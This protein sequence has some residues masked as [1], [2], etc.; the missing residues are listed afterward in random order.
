MPLKLS[1]NQRTLF[2]SAVTVL[3]VGSV[4]FLTFF[5][6]PQE[7]DVVLITIDAL[8]ADH[9]GCYGYN[10]DTS[11]NIDALAREGTLFTQAIAQAS[12]TP[13]S[14]GI[15]TT[16]TYPPTHRLLDWGDTLNPDIPTLAESLKARGYK[17]VFAGANPAFRDGLHGSS[18]GFDE[19][20]NEGVPASVLT[21]KASELVG[22]DRSKPFFLWI[23]YMDVHDYAPSKEFEG[24]Y[25]NDKFYDKQKKLPIIKS[26]AGRYSF[27]GIA[28]FRAKKHG[29]IDNPDYYVALYDSAIRSVDQQIGFLLGNLAPATGNRKTLVIITADHGEMLGEHGCYFHH[30]TFLY[31]P[32]LKVPFILHCP[33][34]VPIKKVDA[35]IRAGLDVLPTVLSALKIKRP[36][37]IQGVALIP[38]LTKSGAGSSYVLSETY[39]RTSVRTDDWKLIR[40]S[41]EEGFSGNYELFHLKSDPGEMNNL[42]FVE[43]TH[44]ASLKEK[45]D[46]HDEKFPNTRTPSPALSERAREGLKTLGYLQ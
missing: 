21:Q 17:T 10:R 13:P 12:W 19:F 30:R 40:F 16:S 6:K 27:R 31:E 32:L 20:Y 43:K 42:A 24:L 22:K 46:E 5:N 8:R 7:L 28:D 45:L 1:R 33:N 44:L 3:A 2:F 15:I 9:L 39:H 37:V 14:V 4:C 25:V 38:T 26:V 41:G 23:H 36:A 34:K 18:R 35:Q 29:G 11:P